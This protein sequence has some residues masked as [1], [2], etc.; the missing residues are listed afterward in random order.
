ML[1]HLH[2]YQLRLYQCTTLPEY[3]STALYLSA[4]EEQPY[5]HYVLILSRIATLP[6]YN[7]TWKNFVFEEFSNSSETEDIFNYFK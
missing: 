7:S 2:L 4:I 3:I 5:L 6:D 1:A